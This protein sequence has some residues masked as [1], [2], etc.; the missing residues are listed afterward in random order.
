MLE[1]LPIKVFPFSW[2]SYVPEM[3]GVAATFFTTLTSAPE[4]Q[5]GLVYVTLVPL[6]RAVTFNMF[7][8]FA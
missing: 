6:P 8:N 3:G 1:T 4:L 7:I 5:P 2:R